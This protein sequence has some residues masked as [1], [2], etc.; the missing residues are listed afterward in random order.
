M[1]I[2]ITVLAAVLLLFGATNWLSQE[3]EKIQL[4]EPEG[5]EIAA[6]T[7][8]LAELEDRNL[9]TLQRLAAL[10]Q[11]LAAL[12]NPVA[13]PVVEALEEAE[14]EVAVEETPAPVVSESSADPEQLQQIEEAGLTPVEF[15]SMEARA[16][17]LYLNGFEDEWLQR[18]ER[19]LVEDRIPGARE[20]LR[21]DLGDDAYDRY[22]YASGS[23]NRVR[24]R[25]VMRGSAAEA[26]GL[27]TGDVLLS[28]D[29]RRVFDFEELRRSSYEGELGETVVLEVRRADNSV[30]QLIIPRGPMGVSGYRGW[31]EPPG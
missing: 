1:K 27:A 20:R 14:V 22:L 9:K 2:A 17:E 4:P 15:Q 31:R 25:T 24:I 23:S 10:E 19:Y 6:L 7:L 13:S 18:R 5:E 16:Y 28:Y 3:P 12:R 30:S 8:Q 26:A 21:Q 11:E 29:G